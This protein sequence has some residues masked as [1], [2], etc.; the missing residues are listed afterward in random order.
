[1]KKLVSA[2]AVGLGLMLASCTQDAP[3]TVTI[4]AAPAPNPAVLLYQA[5]ID[6]LASRIKEEHPRPFR[7]ISEPDFDAIVAEAKASI[8]PDHA[9]RD[10]LWAFSRILTSLGCGH[11][12]QFYFNQEN[13][14]IKPEDRFPVDVR[15]VEWLCENVWF[16]CIALVIESEVYLEALYSRS[17][18]KPVHFIP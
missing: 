11:T 4:A 9:Q 16:C 18:P 13:S 12:R 14:L 3:S 6:L 10:T 17:G 15:Y 2:L 7:I 5:D 8:R 1:M